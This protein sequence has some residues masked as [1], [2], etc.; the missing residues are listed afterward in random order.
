[1]KLDAAPLHLLQIVVR[2]TEDRLHRIVAPEDDEL[3]V[4][5]RVKAIAR[6]S[7]TVG[8]GRCGERIALADGMVAFEM[9]SGKVEQAFRHH[10]ARIGAAVLG[11][12]DGAE[13]RRGAVLVADALPFTGDD[14]SRF[15]PRDALELA[16]AALPHPLHRIL[17]AIRMVDESSIAAAAHACAHDRH[18]RVYFVVPAG[19]DPR[20]NAV[21]DGGLSW[22]SCPR[23]EFEHVHTTRSTSRLPRRRPVPRAT[24]RI[25][26]LK[27]EVPQLNAFAEFRSEISTMSLP[28]RKA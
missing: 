18:V 5:Q 4:Q 14:A 8:V 28:N 3:G 26:Q 2:V 7:D 1:M 16:F 27:T 13:A 20:Q 17:E 11:G 19:A 22:H 25:R 21:L 9:A 10:Y 15:V 23:I 12:V 24:S 6:G